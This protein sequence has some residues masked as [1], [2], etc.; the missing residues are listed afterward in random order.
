[1]AKISENIREGR[2]IWFAHVE[3]K[4]EEGVVHVMR[5]ACGWELKY[6]K[7]KSEVKRCYLK[8]HED[9]S[10]K[11]R[12]TRPK[13]MENENLMHPPRKRPKKRLLQVHIHTSIFD[14]CFYHLSVSIFILCKYNIMS[15][16]VCI[17]IQCYN[18]K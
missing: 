16:I 4:T 1:M 8:E 3:R 18:C 6:G 9:T 11:R 2:L 13:N 14:I 12:I 7:I 17:F 15:L 10:T 5:I